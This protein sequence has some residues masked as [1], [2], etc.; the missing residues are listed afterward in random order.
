MPTHPQHSHLSRERSKHDA[1]RPPYIPALPAASPSSTQAGASRAEQAQRPHTG[2]SARPPRRLR[3]L[4]PPL[5]SR[6]VHLFSSHVLRP[7]E[8]GASCR[9]SQRGPD[10]VSYQRRGV[11]TMALLAAGA[12]LALSLSVTPADAFT[13]SAFPK[14]SQ[15]FH[16]HPSHGATCA[17]RRYCTQATSTVHEACRA[18]M[19]T[20]RSR[21]ECIC[22]YARNCA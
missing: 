20:V 5:S 2:H 7:R 10:C 18:S 8:V 13:L 11:S 9:C 16:R 22:T 15:P 6:S 4:I 17:S 1:P 19:E 14:C 12:V 3:A 21:A